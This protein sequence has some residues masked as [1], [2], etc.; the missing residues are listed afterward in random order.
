MRCFVGW[1]C[2]KAIQWYQIRQSWWTPRFLFITDIFNLNHCIGGRP[3][4]RND[5]HIHDTKT[6]GHCWWLAPPD[7]LILIYEELI[8]KIPQEGNGLQVLPK[9][10]GKI[11]NVIWCRSF[12]IISVSHHLNPN[13]IYAKKK[14]KKIS[15]VSL[16]S[17]E[18]FNC[19]GTNIR[20]RT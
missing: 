16:I 9:M 19:I 3:L 8:F 1:F 12:D 17:L 18:K 7:L 13:K 10:N 15:W 20:P 4:K 2:F 11:S 14:E 6:D 5:Q